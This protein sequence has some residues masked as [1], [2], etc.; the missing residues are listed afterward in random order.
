MSCLYPQNLKEMNDESDFDDGPISKPK[1]NA[2]ALLNDA[3]MVM[4]RKTLIMTIKRMN[5]QSKP[6]Q[7]PSSLMNHRRIRTIK[8]ATTEE[9][10]NYETTKQ[11]SG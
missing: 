11:N 8:E 3:T 6:E 5:Q 2:F 4:T 9:G 1:A 10:N 7:H